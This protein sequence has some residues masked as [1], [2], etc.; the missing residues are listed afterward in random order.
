MSAPSAPPQH[1]DLPDEAYRD[2]TRILRAG[3][4]VALA[5]LTGGVIA[6]VA[7]NPSLAFTTMLAQNPILRYLGLTGLAQGLAGGTVEAY[8]TLGVLA[9]VATPIA[10]V[11]TGSYFF[12]RNGER[13][14]ATI[15]VLVASMLVI[16]VLVV[17]PL[18]R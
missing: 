9:L 8:L 7:L 5:L 3:L 11:V 12:A 1:P 16:G 10:R 6:F 15:T 17:G 2:M 18:V 4:S 13:E 14:L